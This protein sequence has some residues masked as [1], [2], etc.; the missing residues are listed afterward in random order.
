MLPRVL[1][2]QRWRMLCALIL[3]GLV[4]SACLLG[5]VTAARRY[6]DE[7]RLEFGAV[8]IAVVT[9]AILI[10]A[11]GR[12]IERF[13]AEKLAQK[14]VCHLRQQV[15]DHTLALPV[16]DRETVNKGG[17][18]LRLTSD[19]TAIRNWI[20]QGLA[21]LVVLGIWFSVA[22]MG[23]LQLHIALGLSLMLPI[24]LAIVGNYLIGKYLYQSSEQVRRRRS[25]LIR[26]TTEKLRQFRLIKL[27]NQ[28]GK[29]K[30][31]FS[32]QSKRLLHSQLSKARISALLRGFNEAVVLGAVFILLLTGLHLSQTGQMPAEYIAVILTAALYLLAQMRR[33]SRLY[34]FWTLKQ[35]AH[36]KLTRFL[37]RQTVPDEG[38]RKLP[39]KPLHIKLRKV[40]VKHR[41]KSFSADLQ[42]DSRVAISGRQGSGKSSVLMMLAGLLPLTHGKLVFNRRDSANL[43]PVLWA[44]TVALVSHELPL[45]SGTL[46]SNVFYGARQC[47]DQFTKDI[48]ILTGL[49]AEMSEDGRVS[50]RTIHEDG[51]NISNGMRF[52]IM[53]ARALLR[54]PQLLLIDNDAALQDVEIQRVLIQVFDQFNGAIV[55]AADVPELSYKMTATWD[56]DTR[57]KEHHSG[58]FCS[59]SGVANV[60]PFDQG[61]KGGRID[62]T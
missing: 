12:F 59:A 15:F 1:S 3:T 24:L 2:D 25:V 14:Y 42:E 28:H 30:R 61:L 54:R 4:Q 16:T 39:K 40:A 38:R 10:L 60:V 34:E 22:V 47:S 36:D 58:D 37:R 18:L 26:N 21:P 33:L 55:M 44:Q 45:L 23:L 17:T 50:Q 31:V 53:L 51:T 49:D 11:G 27:F 5:L 52:R 56:L 29:E 57:N 8:E 43:H 48:L 7:N 62:V 19:M 9:A 41:F 20:V 32:R 46:K 35:V 6:V 13:V